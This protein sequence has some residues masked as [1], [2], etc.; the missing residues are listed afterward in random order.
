MVKRDLGKP[1]RRE[2]RGQGVT[3]RMSLAVSEKELSLESKNRNQSVARPP[4][5][6]S[7]IQGR[8]ACW[9]SLPV[10]GVGT[11]EL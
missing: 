9:I 3:I 6:G 10:L 7:Q 5:G 2:G 4:S 8:R 11:A 1:H